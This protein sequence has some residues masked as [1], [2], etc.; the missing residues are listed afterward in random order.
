MEK[1][2]LKP[3]YEKEEEEKNNIEEQPIKENTAHTAAAEEEKE[4]NGESV[5]FEGSSLGKFKNAE[6]LMQAYNCLQKEFTKKSQKLSE[7]TKELESMKDNASKTAPSYEA[8]DWQ[9][10]VNN[11]INDN[12]NAKE[13]VTEIEELV[14]SDKTI[15]L[16]SHPLEL[17][18]Y[19][20]LT[21]KFSNPI[22]KIEQKKFI[23]KYILNNSKIGDMVIK[24]YLSKLRDKKSTPMISNHSGSGFSLP[25]KSKPNTLEE[26]KKL[27]EALFKI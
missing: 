6:S 2:E 13:Y 18:Y 21:S 12:P 1:D 27:A 17:A 22:N 14:K 23:N 16:S 19:K 3:L 20:I 11:F 5:T 10:K 25:P 26:A 7:T 9:E 8:E 24:N 15:S 4:N